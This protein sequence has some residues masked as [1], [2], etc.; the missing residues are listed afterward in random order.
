MDVFG[1]RHAPSVA[2]ETG[3]CPLCTTEGPGIEVEVMLC[4]IMFLDQ[5][6]EHESA[7]PR[8][9]FQFAIGGRH[10]EPGL[11]ERATK[12]NGILALAVLL[13]EDELPSNRRQPPRA[14]RLERIEP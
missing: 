6:L 4:A 13:S 7:T 8:G 10:A 11:G 14:R 9:P 1:R 5:P 3:Q 12:K 2:G